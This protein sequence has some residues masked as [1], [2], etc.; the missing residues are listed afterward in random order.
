MLF[1]GVVSAASFW[2]TYKGNEIIRVQYAGVT[3]KPKDV[4][5]ISYDGRTMIP[6]TM[7]GNMGISYNWDKETKTIDLI[8]Q[9]KELNSN[10][11]SNQIKENIRA[12]DYFNNLE[13]LGEI[14]NGLSSFYHTANNY[15]DSNHSKTL[16]ILSDANKHLNGA[17]DSYN[18][19]IKNPSPY[20]DS[21]SQKILD[22]YFSAL[23][24]YKKM[25]TALNKYYV[26]KSTV[27]SQEFYDNN[28]YGFDESA[29]GI[30]IAGERYTYFVNQALFI[31]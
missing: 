29:E 16:D 10:S 20:N 31:K 14:I 22:H 17:I 28:Q 15:V 7:L 9:S 30:S 25:D 27:S 3:V 1:C 8:N 23:E 11:N 26:N 2:G 18:Y 19:I 24:Y 5:A 12:A 13:E 6:L 21:H 4:P